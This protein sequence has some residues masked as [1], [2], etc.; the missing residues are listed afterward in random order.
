MN[1]N[2]RGSRP[3]RGHA[4]AIVSALALLANASTVQAGTI[5]PNNDLARIPAA[6]AIRPILDRHD[7]VLVLVDH[8]VGLLS[9]VRDIDGALLRHN[10][11]AMVR[12]ARIMGVPVIIT[13]VESN[14]MWGPTLPELVAAAPDVKIIHRSQINAWDNPD[15]RAAIKATGRRQVL[16]AGISTETC[17]ALP[18]LSMRAEG[19]DSRV[20]LDASGTFSAAKHEAGIQRLTVAGVPLVDYATAMV[21]ML[22]DNNDPLA[23]QVYGALDMEVSTLMTQLKP[24]R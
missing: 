24:G 3:L 21:E 17:A 4:I 12:A 16:I 23:G 1:I 8:Q 15:V 20:V 2:H 6:S 14:G 22:G 11:V 9:G 5:K 19:Y 13:A 7:T 10:L 18:A